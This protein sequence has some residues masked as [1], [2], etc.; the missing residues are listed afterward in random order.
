LRTRPAAEA[1]A[2]YDAAESV[3]TTLLVDLRNLFDAE[4]G[5]L[6]S[7]AKQALFT[8]DILAALKQRDD[9][10]WPEWRD[11][12]PITSRQLASLLK[13][14]GIPTNKTVRRG[15]QTDKGYQRADL[16]DAFARYAPEA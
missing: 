12:Q 6:F 1:A 11:G 16:E 8:R 9:R 14:L 4:I 5:S 7:P 15:P 3:T 2:T 13:P 10:P